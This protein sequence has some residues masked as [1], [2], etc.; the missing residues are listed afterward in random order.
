M[1]EEDDFK[2]ELRLFR[3]DS[4][5][6]FLMFGYPMFGGWLP[7]LAFETQVNYDDVFNPKVKTKYKIFVAEWFLRGYMFIYHI[8]ESDMFRGRQ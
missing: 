1:D 4:Y 7:R 2:P 8:E 3:V 5:N 6:T